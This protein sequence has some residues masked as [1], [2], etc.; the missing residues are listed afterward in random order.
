MKI[1]EEARV[2][3]ELTDAILHKA[4]VKNQVPAS[5]S[6]VFQE[7]TPIIPIEVATPFP[8]EKFKKGLEICPRTAKLPKYKGKLSCMTRAVAKAPFPTSPNKA[9]APYFAPRTLVTFEVPTFPEP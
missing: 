5:I 1:G 6:P 8:P 9:K 4:R 2:V 7:N 3:N